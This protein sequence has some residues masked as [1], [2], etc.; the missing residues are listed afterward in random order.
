MNY[1]NL[2]YANRNDPLDII[3]ISN[4]QPNFLYETTCPIKKLISI[5]LTTFCCFYYLINTKSSAVVVIREQ[6]DFAKKSFVS[7]ACTNC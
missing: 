6:F 5:I 3:N 4:M 2:N 7:D 1:I